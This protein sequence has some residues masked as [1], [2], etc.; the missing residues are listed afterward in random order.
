MTLDEYLVWADKVEQGFFEAA[1]FLHSQYVFN[2]WD[3]PYATQLVPLAVL[4]VELGSDLEDANARERLEHWYWSGIFG[5]A[6]GS[7]IETQY[8]RDLEQVA[9]Y[10]RTGAEPLL[11]EEANFVPQRLLTLRTRN[12]AAY[13]GLY[14]LQMKSGAADWRTGEKLTLAT[15]HD[16]AI[17]IHHI[18]P[19]AWCQADPPIPADLYNSIINKTPIDAG[20]NRRIGGRAPSEYLPRLRTRYSNLDEALQAH[21]VN[22]EHLEEDDFYTSFI[23]RG[24]QMLSLIGNAMRKDIQGGREVF[25]TALLRGM[26]EDLIPEGEAEDADDDAELQEFDDNENEYDDVSNAEYGVEDDE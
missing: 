2:A 18:F 23:E 20:T 13:K 25:R 1:K 5:E 22:P 12:I 21:W 4:F 19:V 7:A 10:V 9:V 15:Y 11:V 6:Y 26:P 14:A 8:A 3:V 17:D 16:E 24:E